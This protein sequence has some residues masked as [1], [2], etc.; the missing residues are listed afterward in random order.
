MS[1]DYLPRRGRLLARRALFF[2][3]VGPLIIGSITVTLLPAPWIPYILAGPPASVTGLAYALAEIKMRDALWSRTFLRIAVTSSFAILFTFCWIFALFL[4]R[5]RDHPIELM[6]SI[7]DA[8]GH[9]LALSFIIGALLALMQPP[10]T[11]EGPGHLE[12][13]SRP[14]PGNESKSESSEDT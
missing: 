5:G 9:V 13:W 10:L 1:N 2:A 8:S 7:F 4:P 3:F 14:I 12:S 11:S 6:A